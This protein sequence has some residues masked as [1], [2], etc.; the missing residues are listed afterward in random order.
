MSQ[1]PS[2]ITV[3]PTPLPGV[4][5]APPLVS[6]SVTQV[7]CDYYFTRGQ[8]VDTPHGAICTQPQHAAQE[9]CVQHFNK[10]GKKGWPRGNG[11]PAPAPETPSPFTES[12]KLADT[13]APLP[14][15]PPP[16][17]PPKIASPPKARSPPKEE[18]LPEPEEPAPPKKVIVIKQSTPPP[19]AAPAPPRGGADDEVPPGAIILELK[20]YRDG[21]PP[22]EE[23]GALTA[24]ATPEADAHDEKWT[25]Q[26]GDLYRHP[27][28]K[29]LGEA[30][31]PESLEGM[32]PKEKV[33]TLH[34][35]IKNNT[36]EGMM[37]NG[38]RYAL[39]PIAQGLGGMAGMDLENFG[40][41]I[42]LNE[43]EFKQLIIMFRIENE[44]WVEK[45]AST[46]VKFASLMITTAGI[47]HTANTAR[48]AAI[49]ESLQGKTPPAP[50]VKAPPPTSSLSLQPGLQA[51]AP[52][53]VKVQAKKEVGPVVGM[54]PSGIAIVGPAPAASLSTVTKSMGLREALAA[55]T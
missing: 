24:P 36:T 42:D 20:G 32:D 10:P 47:V 39:P 34:R 19:R 21:P 33:K 1:L 17:P 15:G 45:I 35:A 46:Q 22:A 54:S 13:P 3:P 6:S 9:R 37:W 2:V 7:L 31:P 38:L 12:K 55:P 43:Q 49:M 8:S 40:K 18:K 44:E 48:K 41:G 28:L 50:T 5:V 16:P 53:E 30:V 26:L 11:P 29:W 23:E 14:P 25:H 52:P 51:P 27:T 4:V